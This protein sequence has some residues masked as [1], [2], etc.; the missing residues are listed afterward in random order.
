M[1][2]GLPH[3]P[4]NYSLHF[5][6]RRLCGVGT[7]FRF[8]ASKQTNTKKHLILPEYS[9]GEQSRVVAIHKKLV[10]YVHYNYKRARA[11]LLETQTVTHFWLGL[12]HTQL[13]HKHARETREHTEPGSHVASIRT[14][15]HKQT[16][17]RSSRARTPA[18]VE[19]CASAAFVLLALAMLCCTHHE[20]II[21]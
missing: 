6:R 5:L 4:N 2:T 12:S 16:E 3:T 13:A 9:N 7:K 20:H 19:R 1:Y 10:V 14:E 17:S 11:P 18:V 21:L 8:D 15:T